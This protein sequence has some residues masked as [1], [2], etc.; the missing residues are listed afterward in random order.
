MQGLPGGVRNPSSEVV[1][2]SITNVGAY[3]LGR[4]MFGGGPGPWA[5]GPGGFAWRGWWGEDP[6]Y[7]APVFVL[8][9][10]ARPPLVMQ[11]GTTFTFVTDGLAAAHRQAVAAAAGKDVVIGGGASVVRQCLAAG[12]VDEVGVSLVPVF[13]GR[14]ERLF[15]G[16]GEAGLKLVQVRAVEAPGVTHL[17]YRVER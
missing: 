2:A 14:G 5:P 8:T 17:R 7:H 16:L 9:H 4:N 12:L 13:L 10:H 6:P 1:E 3:L 15:E 11:G